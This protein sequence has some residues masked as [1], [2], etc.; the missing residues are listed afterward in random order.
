MQFIFIMLL[1][2]TTT[3]SV[4]EDYIV[5]CYSKSENNIKI[6]KSASD[7]KVFDLLPSL[8][9]EEHCWYILELSNSKNGRCK[10]KSIKIQPGCRDFTL[11]D[12]QGMWIKSSDDL[13]IHGGY[14]Y[15]N[16]RYLPLYT[17]PSTDSGKII[18]REANY[19]FIFL[20]FKDRWIK[21]AYMEAGVRK[22]GW[23]RPEDQCCL[24]WTE[25]N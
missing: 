11:P 12:Y 17:E 2:I 18:M 22:S 15:E 24:P 3:F 23:K 5:C 13:K 9:H 1:S 16:D 10:I 6:Y 20:D 8:A 21:V 14:D 7:T 25:C 19:D 4:K